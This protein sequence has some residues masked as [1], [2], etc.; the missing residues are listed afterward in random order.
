[1]GNNGDNIDNNDK[2]STNTPST[3]ESEVKEPED[4]Q[5][6]A[7]IIIF[8]PRVKSR[9]KVDWSYERLPRQVHQQ[10][11]DGPKLRRVIA[12]KPNHWQYKMGMVVLYDPGFKP[13]E[14][15]LMNAF[16][17]LMGER[18]WEKR[19]S[20]RD[21]FNIVGG[22]KS[23][24]QLRMRLLAKYRFI[25]NIQPVMAKLPWLAVNPF[26]LQWDFFGLRREYSDLQRK[27]LFKK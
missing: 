24:F 20:R 19:I 2:S 23:K 6:L 5:K 27:K 16:L 4:D 1:M 21:I 8:A 18:K 14:Q 3:P 15:R 11:F 17:D 7:D 25:V 13:A 10:Y 9:K 26:F 12:S 22:S